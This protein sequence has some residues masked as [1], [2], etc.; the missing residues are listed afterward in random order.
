MFRSTL[1]LAASVALVL[2]ASAFASES[3]DSVLSEL[4]RA[5]PEAAKSSFAPG[6]VFKD[7]SPESLVSMTLFKERLTELGYFMPDLAAVAAD[8]SASAAYTTGSG[9][10]TGVSSDCIRPA[11]IPALPAL[12]ALRSIEHRLSLQ[13]PQP[14]ADDALDGSSSGSAPETAE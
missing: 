2:P 10:P 12:E 3:H 11:L 13:S 8:D 4:T 5:C 7:A 6:R 14:L 1:L 9:D